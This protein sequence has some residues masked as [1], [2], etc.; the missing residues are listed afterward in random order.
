MQKRVSEF[1]SNAGRSFLRTYRLIGIEKAD[2]H[3]CHALLVDQKCR[4]EPC[5]WG[6]VVFLMV[7]G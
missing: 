3:C 4:G 6:H 2:C 7:T 1:I 5:F